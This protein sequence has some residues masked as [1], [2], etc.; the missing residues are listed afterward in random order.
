MNEESTDPVP[1]LPTDFQYIE[2][3]Y[4]LS[5][6]IPLPDPGFLEMCDCT[7]ACHDAELCGCQSV[8]DTDVRGDKSFAYDTTVWF[9]LC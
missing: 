4:L 3:R 7:I 9:T 8:A 5:E 2:G 1:P 6:G